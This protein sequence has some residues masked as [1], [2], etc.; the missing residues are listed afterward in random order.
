MELSKVTSASQARIWPKQ[1]EGYKRLQQ[2]GLDEPGQQVGHVGEIKP[3]YLP[4]KGTPAS[5]MPGHRSGSAP[6]LRLQCF[7]S[8]LPGGES[9]VIP[10]NRELAGPFCQLC[11]L[12]VVL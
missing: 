2:P 10:T 1:G 9:T 8:H 6:A 7:L 4:P 12:T 5:L 3:G 11:V